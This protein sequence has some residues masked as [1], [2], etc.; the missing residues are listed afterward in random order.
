MEYKI[1]DFTFR[2]VMPELRVIG[3]Y[4]IQ[5]QDGRF[6]IGS[7][8]QSFRQRWKNHINDLQKNK[9]HCHYL[10]NIYNKY[11]ADYLSFTIVEVVEDKSS[12]LERE[13]HWIDLLQPQLNL[14]KTAGSCLGYKFSEEIKTK[15]RTIRREEM[16]KSSHTGVRQIKSN[17]RYQ[18]QIRIPNDRINLGV[19]GT[20]EEALEARL[21]GEALF[22]SEE[23]DSKTDKEKAAVVAEFRANHNGYLGKTTSEKALAKKRETV[24]QMKGE[25]LGI[26]TLPH[27]F[28]ATIMIDGRSIYLGRYTHKYEAINVRKE[29]EEFY[30]SEELRAKPKEERLQIIRQSV[31]EKIFS[32]KSTL[33]RSVYGKHISK[34][35]S[36]TYNFSHKKT[37]HSKNFPTLEE[38]VTYKTKYLTSIEAPVQI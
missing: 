3:I 20:Y 35:R 13:Q 25:D 31:D 8:S 15:H 17:G 19:Y 5:S 9:H 38:A 16:K 18:A 32:S 4:K 6:Y 7:A 30:Y 21:K 27:C 28:E 23:F 10:Q 26:T 37:K 11:G 14:L 2:A 24:R 36:N 1:S 29:A 12:I 33:V 22:W 34:T